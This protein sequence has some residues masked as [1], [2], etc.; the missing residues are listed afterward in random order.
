MVR[1]IDWENQID[2]RLKLRNLRVF[3][4]VVQ[5]GSMAKAAEQLGVSPPS[6]SEAIADLEHTLGVR[7]VDR[8]AQ[9]IEPTIYGD[10]LLRRSVAVFDELKQ[11][12]RDIEFLSD[13]TTGELRIACVEG[14]WYTFLPE[15]M[16]RF[17]ERY[18]RVKVHADLTLHAWEFSGL[19]ERKYDCML[20]RVPM[21]V[22]KQATDHL[23]YEFLFDET[24]SVVAGAHTKWARRRKID[25]AELIDEP[26]IPSGPD[27]WRSVVEEIFRARGLNAP[28]PRMTT[29]SITLR[30]RLVAAGPYLTFYGHSILR[31]LLADRYAITALPVDVPAF[32]LSAYIVT[33]KNRTL[34]AVVERFLECVREVVKPSAGQPAGRGARSAKPNVS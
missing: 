22:H 28:E 27:T 8:S 26:W 1:K 23:N 31:Q 19:R 33:L 5:C 17:L 21:L 12:I 29:V 3:S 24:V 9:G 6:V 14:L 4:T 18:P 34:S 7:L 32:P 13:P 30:A 20:E 10:A 15:I 16:R 25:L 2:R 11:S